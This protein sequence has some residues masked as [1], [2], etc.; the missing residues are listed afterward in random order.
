MSLKGIRYI[1]VYLG[2]ACNY[3]C[4]YCD[5]GYIKSIGSQTLKHSDTDSI[6]RFFDWVWKQ[7]APDLKFIGMHGGEPFLFISRM[8]DILTNLGPELRKRGLRVNITTNG[9]LILENKD[10]IEKWQDILSMNWSYDFNFQSI[11]REALE[12]KETAD[13]VRTTKAGLY[14]Q[15]VCPED[16]FNIDTAAE[17]INT[18]R[19]A[20]VKQI[21]I[22]P[23]RHHRGAHKFKSF[24]EQM[25]LNRFVA[26]FLPFLQTLYVHG[27]NVSIDGIY[28]GK[29]DK[30]ILDNHGKF[31]LSPDGYIYPEFDFLEYQRP[32]YRIGQWNS[33]IPTLSRTKDEDSLLL[34]HCRTCPSK[35]LCGLK[36]MY[37]MFSV[38]PG[39]KCEEFYKIIDITQ[40]HLYNLKSQPSL[41]HW[42][43]PHDQT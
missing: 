14:F 5:R 10:F 29:I 4:S 6:Y 7:E 38:E 19:L 30:H 3:D 2:D 9:S 33:E 32:E 37:A 20:R 18:C 35:P 31:I 40:K 11:N 43:P 24:V 28:E 39:K 8:D 41:L 13:F 23:L 27:L 25:D 34:R 42:F 36:Y 15:F 22:I 1:S 12:V 16:A 17:V 26:N 21:N